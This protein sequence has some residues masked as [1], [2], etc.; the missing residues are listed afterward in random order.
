MECG[1]FMEMPLNY[2]LDIKIADDYY[3]AKISAEIFSND[4]DAV[5]SGILED[6]KNA[7][8]VFGIDLDA[9]KM[10]CDEGKD[11]QDLLIAQGSPHVNGVDATIV[12]NIDLKPKPHPTVNE[13]G[14]VD[15]KDMNYLKI[16]ADGELLAT[17]IPVKD[18]RNGITVTGRDIKYKPGK[19]VL[20]KPGEN[21]TLSED[22]LELIATADGIAKLINNRITIVSQM[23]IKAVGPETGNIY[24]CGDVHVKETVLDGYTVN[25]DGDLTVDGVVEGSTLKVKGNLTVGRG[26]M[27][28][29]DSD[30]VVDGNLV[31]KFIENANLYVKGNIETGEI[32]NSTVLCDGEIKV[33]G[34]KGLII[35]GEITSKYMIEANRIGSKL[36]VITTINLGIDRKCV[37]EL[38]ILKETVQELKIVEEKLKIKLIELKKS[39][40]VNPEDHE[41]KDKYQQYKDSL[42]S[43]TIFLE[44]K[45]EQMKDLVEKLKFSNES[46]LKIS[47]IYPDTLVKIGDH[48]YFVDQALKDC[49]IRKSDDKVVAIGY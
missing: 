25:C 9:L 21:T 42:L 41:L 32:I 11:F 44:E 13:D 40:V 17:K 31:S 38:K 20:I 43:T 3:S 8:I 34:S 35:G 37:N 5:F 19:D 16:I 10:H 27:G 30:I 14:S 22:G 26:I 48:S 1:D 33:V 49:I 36:G 6:L 18:G 2:K 12:Y 7:N 46:Q 4:G 24:F 23:D 39:V 29:G 15:F 45:Q 28:H 47:T